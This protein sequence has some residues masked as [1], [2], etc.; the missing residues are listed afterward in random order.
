MGMTEM[1]RA[2]TEALGSG[3]LA[4]AAKSDVRRT[5]IPESD[6]VRLLCDLGAKL[7]SE[8]NSQTIYEETLA[9]AIKLTRADAGTVQILD[10][11]DCALVVLATR[12]FS[13]EVV[14]H[15][16]RLDASSN[17]SCGISLSTGV[18]AILHFDDPGLPDPDGSLKMHMDEGYR[19]AQSTPLITRSGRAIGMLSTHWRDHHEPTEQELGY[20]DLLARQAADLIDHRRSEE[21]L[22]RSEAEL[23]QGLA[24]AKL[25]QEISIRI[26]EDDD[27]I[28]Q[29][30]MDGAVAATGS[31]FGSLQLLNPET[32]ELQLLAWKAFDAPTAAAWQRVE[33]NACVA[34]SRVL[35][36]GERYIAANVRES[37]LMRGSPTAAF[38]EA[39]GIQSVVYTPLVSR[40]GVIV[41]LI[42]NHWRELHHPSERELRLLDVIARQAA[43]LI[44]RKKSEEGL[45]R[46]QSD[47]RALFNSIDEG[48]CVIEMIFDE[49]GKP[50]DYRFLKVNP[51]FERHTG[52]IGA[53]G[54]TIRSLA[55]GHEEEW[56]EVYGRVAAAGE[57]VRFELPAAEFNDRWYDVYA[58]RVGEPEQRQVAVLFNDISVRH[59]AESALRKDRERQVFLLKLSDTLRPLEDPEEIQVEACRVIGEHLGANR[60]SYADIEGDD[61]IINRS[62]VYDAAEMCGRFPLEAFGKSWAETYEQEANIAVNDIAE[63]PLLSAEERANFHASQIRAFVAVRLVKAGEWVGAFAV[64]QKTPRVWKEEEIELVREVGERTWAAVERAKAKNALRDTD[65]RLKLALS[66][67]SMGTFVWDIE[68]DRGQPDEQMLALFGQAPDCTLTLKSALATL[69]HPEDWARYRDSVKRAIDPQGNGELHEDIRVIRPDGSQRWLAITAQVYFEGRPRRAVR[70]AGAALDITARKTS[71]ALIRESEH[72]LRIALESAQMGAWDW[73]VTTDLVL[74][75]ERHFLLFG[76]IPHQEPMNPTYFSSFLHPEDRELVF[77]RLMRAVETA[78][79]FRAE[80]R[81]IRADNGEV[82][83]MSGY[84]HSV[85]V[86]KGR[87]MRMTG[88]LFDCT[89]RMKT[90]EELRLAHTELESRVEERTRELAAAMERLSVEIIERRK[91]QEERGELLKRLVNSQEEERTRISRE[92]HDNLGQNMVA[93]KL[94]LDA[95]QR[96][97]ASPAWVDGNDGITEL[98]QVV[99]Q[100]IKGVHRQA[101]ELRPPELAHMG[102]EV[103]LQHYVSDWSTR[104]GIKTTF[105]ATRWKY[106]RLTPEIEI[107]LYRV[108]QEALT[109]VAR[110][111]NASS[112]RLVMNSERGVS[113]SIKDDGK[114][115]EPGTV[116]G[117]LGLLGMKE[118]M[119]IIG[120][121]LE[122]SS[123]PGAGTVVQAS[124]P[125]DSASSRA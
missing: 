30:V 112:I 53:V 72:R 90:E 7:V 86:R 58:F 35:E 93:V 89:D 22:R 46:S 48:F 26:I 44:E 18:R 76:L 8:E 20:I 21:A 25:L 56:F 78:S 118:R 64:H 85:A 57:P 23:A 15:F 4:I 61:F 37:A 91:A 98:R 60:V 74:W 75:N 103:A 40:R 42:A 80:F 47:Y 100:L 69:M 94:H 43:D 3:S 73:D 51:A 54:Q 50:V 31:D 99:D 119:V 106:Q 70:M 81:I 107:A 9:A 16:Q 24:D 38:Y 29:H 92:L 5:P 2:D 116:N 122:I 123:S 68:E 108:V 117:R 109:N 36:S 11:V 28:Y 1:I 6:G 32:H 14:R 45:T 59:R 19:S 88:V 82:R 12:G 17:T 114:G 111:A 55:P 62:Y 83:W 120:G 115:F 49:A 34:G 71:E 101:W 104:S 10:E 84:G 63:Y 65:E 27:A 105:D 125:G 67:A 96:G 113:I 41:G 13:P 87:A 79:P 102:L 52:I 77:T 33:R 124:L 110:H 121:T 39:V 97:S 95:L 66:A